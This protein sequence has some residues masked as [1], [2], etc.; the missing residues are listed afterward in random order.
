MVEEEKITMK[1]KDE[2][3]KSRKKVMN[4]TWKGINI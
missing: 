3:Q 2:R 1:K 4:G